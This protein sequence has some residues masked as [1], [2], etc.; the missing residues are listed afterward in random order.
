MHGFSLFWVQR[1]LVPR[2][3]SKPWKEG[4]QNITMIQS[5]HVVFVVY[6]GLW[7]MVCRD[8]KVPED[9]PEAISQLI[10]QC[11]EAKP[12]DRPSIREVFN[13][14][15]AHQ[16]IPS[17]ETS[18]DLRKTSGSSLSQELRSA[19]NRPNF[20][21]RIGVSLVCFSVIGALLC[22]WSQAHL[23]VDHLPEMRW[24]KTFGF[25]WDARIAS[26]LGQ[27]LGFVPWANLL[28]DFFGLPSCFFT[29]LCF[30]PMDPNS[31]LDA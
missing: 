30:R 1:L 9:C 18:N 19:L 22:A 26:W 31:V 4:V 6:I 17:R 10:D 2:L 8:L 13:V 5:L 20:W 25:A 11:L 15:K 24:D 29:L 27:V 21:E 23:M 28:L 7:C 14:L 16:T 3:V 12:H